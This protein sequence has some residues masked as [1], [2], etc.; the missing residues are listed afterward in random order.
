[1]KRPAIEVSGGSNAPLRFC[2]DLGHLGLSLWTELEEGNCC[3][4]PN[5]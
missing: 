4:E 3:Y 2:C 1:M 5:F